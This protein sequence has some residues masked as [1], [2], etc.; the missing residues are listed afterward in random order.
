MASQMSQ[1]K[2]VDFQAIH[3]ES[4]L[5]EDPVLAEEKLNTKELKLKREFIAGISGIVNAAFTPAAKTELVAVIIDQAERLLTA[6]FQL[7]GLDI[8]KR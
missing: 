1:A 2:V 7:T 4:P 5:P 6:V 3:T 8:L